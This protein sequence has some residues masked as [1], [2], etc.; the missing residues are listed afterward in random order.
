MIA[1][2]GGRRARTDAFARRS[3]FAAARRP[4][5]DFECCMA[6]CTE[7]GCVRRAEITSFLPGNWWVDIATD[8]FMTCLKMNDLKAKRAGP[9][10]DEQSQFFGKSHSNSSGEFL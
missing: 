7:N 6:P 9:D 8:T 1:F 10:V 3:V 2:T 4:S 5:S